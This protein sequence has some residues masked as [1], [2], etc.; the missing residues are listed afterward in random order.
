MTAARSRPARRARPPRQPHQDR[1]G[2]PCLLIREPGNG[3]AD[4]LHHPRRQM[5][6]GEHLPHGGQPRQFDAQGEQAARTPDRHP[7]GRAQPTPGRGMPM[8]SGLPRP[9]HPPD[10]LGQRTRDPIAG[11]QQILGL[12]QADLGRIG[13]RSQGQRLRR[14]PQRGDQ[15]PR[16]PRSPITPTTGIRPS[17]GTTGTGI[18]TGGIRTG[19]TGRSVTIRSPAVWSLAGGGLVG[20]GTGVVHRLVAGERTVRRPQRRIGD[21]PI[22]PAVISAIRTM[23][24]LRIEVGQIHRTSQRDSNSCVNSFTPAPHQHP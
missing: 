23:V 12:G 16:R 21:Q 10:T 5:S 3:G 14:L 2:Q 8:L 15:H 11:E 20:S 17:L 1:L 18:G 6:G 7:P 19:R 13:D 24:A 22:P 4:R 9:M